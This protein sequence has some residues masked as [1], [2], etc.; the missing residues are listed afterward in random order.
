MTTAGSLDRRPVSPPLDAFLEAKLQAPRVRPGWVRRLGLVRA[1]DRA[2]NCPLTLVAAPAGY[3]KTT[4]VAQW[5]HQIRDR[6]VAWV[7]LDAADNDPVRLWTHVATALARAGCR[8]DDDVAGLAASHRT[9]ILTSVLPKIIN[10]FG[11]LPR[12]IVIVLDDF[13]LIRA[14]LCREQIEFLI[15]HVPQSVRMVIITRADPALR[16]GRLR[17]SGQLAEIRADRLS[18]DA[19]EA[20]SLLAVE[21]VR[22]SDT[23][24]Q[25]L[26]GRTEG[27]PAALYLA[28]L[29]LAGREDPDA[30][31]H[32]FSGDN[33]FIGEYLTE[34]VLGRHPAAVREF[35][36]SSALFERMCAPLCD[37]VLERSDSRMILQDLE[38]SNLFLLPLD[39]ERQWFRFHHLFAAVA[40]SE[41][42]VGD[43]Q[44]VRRLHDRAADWFAEHGF[45]DEAIRHAIAAGSSTRASL[46]VQ[47]NW[48]RYVD[49]G[50]EA[51]VDHWLQ[52]IQALQAAEAQADP[53]AVVTAAWMAVVT[54][55]EP[56]LNHLLHAL[57]RIGDYGPLPDGTTSVESAIALI[58]AMS[59]YGGPVD[60]LWSARRAVELETDGNSPSFAFANF[61]LGHALYI[62]GDLETATSVLPRAAYN[63]A[64]TA[65]VKTFAFSVMAMAAR[66][67]GDEPRSAAYTAAAMKVVEDTSMQ[68]MSQASPAFTVW[69]ETQAA[70]GNLTGA[71]A[72][73]EHA[74]IL[75]GTIPGLSPWPTIH[76]AIAMGR[77]ATVAGDLPRAE[78]LL[79]EAAQVMSRFPDGMEA[80]RARLAAAR[81]ALRHRRSR[82]PGVQVLTG[83]ELD[84]LGLLQGSMN[85][86]EIASELHL[87]RNTVKTHAQAVYRKLGASSR[88][89]AVGLA[90]QRALI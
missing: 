55:D 62:S 10:S 3:G 37:Y 2:A 86:S 14:G 71:M 36:I 65:I 82:E 29:S 16:I 18:F 72:T 78:Q 6:G 54:G 38:R 30:F 7:A 33:R 85:L 26:V 12:P 13:H 34:E 81:A 75:R 35:I 51:T 44:R 4:L 48:V 11:R 39:A 87:S 60:M 42:E 77:V 19:A 56:T 66:E 59:G 17:V 22:L 79:D 61:A 63:S 88:S 23:S 1:L 27:W 20:S 8:I 52:A 9:Q 58:R 5:I 15:E 53:S 43:A 31:V 80:M 84:I 83:R 47:A 74:F 50:R 69:G 40:R 57:T 45:A 24:V 89:Q 76:H 64:A 25:E 21:G 67:Q 73:L 46:L 32:R 70:M 49:A 41:L 68:A 28:T 90:R